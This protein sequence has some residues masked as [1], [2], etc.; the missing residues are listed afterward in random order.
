MTMVR[1]ETSPDVSVLTVALVQADDFPL[2]AGG[3][4]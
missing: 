4:S 2:S 1:Q 3:E